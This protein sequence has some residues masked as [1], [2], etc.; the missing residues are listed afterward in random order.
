MEYWNGMIVD[1][2]YENLIWI[3]LTFLIPK[4]NEEIQLVK[5]Y[6]K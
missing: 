6:E 3:N 2:R 5:I 1:T 4:L